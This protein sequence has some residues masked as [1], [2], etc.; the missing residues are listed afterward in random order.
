MCYNYKTEEKVKFPNTG[1][2]M[3]KQLI[4]KLNIAHNMFSG[5][6]KKEPQK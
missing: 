6:L 1:I 4:N 5:L 2:T 3:K